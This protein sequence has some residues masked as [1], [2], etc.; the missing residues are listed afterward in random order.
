MPL[1]WLQSPEISVKKEKETLDLYSFNLEKRAPHPC[2]ARGPAH[3]K[4]GLDCVPLRKLWYKFFSSWEKSTI[5]LRLIAKLC[6]TWNR[7]S[8]FPWWLA[9]VV[10][11]VYMDLNV[12]I[13]LD[14]SVSVAVRRFFFQNVVHLQIAIPTI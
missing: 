5:L 10:R 1:C 2:W 13:I 7:D 6:L 4:A 14:C 9:V 12:C 8:L 3:R 11:N